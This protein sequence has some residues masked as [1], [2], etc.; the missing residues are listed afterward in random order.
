MPRAHSHSCQPN[1]YTISRHTS[2]ACIVVNG[3]CSLYL[4]RSNTLRASP[5][6]ARLTETH[7]HTF[8]MSLDRLILHKHYNLLRKSMFPHIQSRRD[9]AI[10]FLLWTFRS[11]MRAPWQTQN[12][13]ATRRK[14]ENAKITC[15]CWWWWWCVV[16]EWSSIWK[17]RLF[18]ASGID[19]DGEY[20][21]LFWLKLLLLLLLML[22]LPSTMV[23]LDLLLMEF[24]I[25]R[26]MR[27]L[28]LFSSIKSRFYFFAGAIYML[29][30]TK[31]YCRNHFSRA[32]V[33][34]VVV[35]AT[36]KYNDYY[37]VKKKTKKRNNTAHT[38]HTYC[39]STKLQQKLTLSF[40]NFLWI[41]SSFPFVLSEEKSRLILGLFFSFFECLVG[42]VCVCWPFSRSSTKR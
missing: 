23:S 2:T 11:S 34:L 30:Q 26:S 39:E 32:R 6:R 15:C 13:K 20:R 10:F 24:P 5:V 4:S 25:K 38:L 29:L 31:F 17:F 14:M 19:G 27:F 1:K 16:V 35:V 3:T 7:S 41:Y 33:T 18:S 22:L 12:A 9:F 37:Y 40:F 28:L 8:S 42:C 21:M 36:N